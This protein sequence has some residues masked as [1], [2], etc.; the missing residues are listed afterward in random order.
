M[1]S[2]PQQ[3]IEPFIELLFEQIRNNNHSISDHRCESI[4]KKLYF[5]FL[6]QLYAFIR[7]ILNNI[8]WSYEHLS[9]TWYNPLAIECI[10]QIVKNTPFKTLL[11]HLLALLPNELNKFLD[12]LQ[13]CPGIPYELEKNI[14][15]AFKHNTP[16]EVN[17]LNVQAPVPISGICRQ[18]GNIKSIPSDLATQIAS[19][20]DQ[21]LGQLMQ[22][23]YQYRVVGLV[24]ALL[25][26]PQTY[27]DLEVSAALLICSDPYESVAETFALFSS[28]EPDFAHQLDKWMVQ[29]CEPIDDLP[30]LGSIWLFK[31]Q[32]HCNSF[33]QK[34]ASF[35][36]GLYGYL[37]WALELAPGLLSLRIWMAVN[38]LLSQW[39]WHKSAKIS[40][41]LPDDIC[42]FLVDLLL[43]PD[44]RKASQLTPIPAWAEKI[45]TNQIEQEAALMLLNLHRAN[46][47]GPQM[48]AAQDRT[49]LFLPQI[50][51]SILAILRDWLY[52]EEIPHIGEKKHQFTSVDPDLSKSIRKALVAQELATHCRDQNRLIVEEAASQLLILSNDGLDVLVEVMLEDPPPTHLRSLCET[53]TLWPE[54]HHLLAIAAY[55]STT[56]NQ[57]ERRFLLASSLYERKQTQWWDIIIESL[58]SKGEHDWFEYQDWLKLLRIKPDKTRLSIELITSPLSVAYSLALQHILQLKDP[59]DQSIIEAFESFLQCGNDHPQSSRL[60]VAQRLQYY[61]LYTGWPLL[62]AKVLQSKKTHDGIKEC[63]IEKLHNLFVNV[64][65]SYIT[66]AVRAVLYAGYEH[67]NI[68]N[69]FLCLKKDN[70]DADSQL[71]ALLEILRYTHITFVQNQA[72]E[73]MQR[74]PQRSQNLSELADTFAWGVNIA[75]ELSGGLF[76][77]KMIVGNDLG[78]T[79]LSGRE[80]FINP[81]PLLRK[82]RNGKQIIHGLILHEIGHHLYHSAKE[83]VE[84]WEKTNR[85]NKLLANLLNLVADEHLERNLRLKDQSFARSLKTLASYAFQHSERDI[86]LLN[87]LQLLGARCFDIL[88]RTSLRPSLKPQNVRLNLGKLFSE[89]EAQGMSFPRFVR[90]LRMGLGNRHSDPL[91]EQ[92]LSLFTRDFRNASMPELLNISK[93]LYEI[94]FPELQLMELL[95]QD[96]MLKNELSAELHGALEGISDEELQREVERILRSKDQDDT[97]GQNS[98]SFR[99]INLS[100]DIAFPL[101][102]SVQTL[103]YNRSEHAKYSAQISRYSIKLREYLLHLGLGY[104]YQKHRTRGQKIDR[105]SLTSSIIKSDPRIL[106]A[107]KTL[108][109][110]DLFIAV[111]IDCSGSM[112]IHDNIER[113]KLFATLIADAAANISGVDAHFL[114]FTDSVLYN[115]GNAQN[116]AVHALQAEGGNNDAAALWYASRLAIA[117]RRKARLIVMISDGSPTECSVDALQQLV[118]KISIKFK[119]CCAQVAVAQMQHICFPHYIE[120][121]DSNINVAVQKFGSMLMKIIHRIISG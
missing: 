80:I 59:L 38:S 24:N 92:A 43:P 105:S 94:F 26:R 44:M 35:P 22:I 53:I 121:T 25:K 69:L 67:I 54:T 104:V 119:I 2:W 48:R 31:W 34:I 118:Q 112:V 28:P 45:L 71:Q 66:T 40:Q 90:A 23:C 49:Q 91:V 57:A 74:T 20:S 60:N 70:L 47:F 46:A 89:L 101:I 37:I 63:D 114:G 77:F 111:I 27:P 93:S 88:H 97:K 33:S 13:K 65:T 117:S 82:E 1:N 76:V 109:K 85:E 79:R 39:R 42:D 83:D 5:I 6:Y 12:L 87:L 7:I 84:L 86:P 73:L 51:R 61:G 110:S 52:L 116:C 41:S 62:L 108:Y 81:L 98:H 29:Q 103:I 14:C 3:E 11:K 95:S 78:Y 100:T 15:E 36:N 18:R 107:R 120:L 55:I 64:P 21:Q 8:I 99:E 106:V 30:L 75:R 102:N 17:S 32:K 19:C 50:S 113:A 96:G 68:N 16:L 56:P 9:T 58:H 72:L 115:A 10:E 4:A